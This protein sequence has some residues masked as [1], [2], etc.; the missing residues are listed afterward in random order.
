MAISLAAGKIRIRYRDGKTIEGFVL[1]RHG[2]T[3]SVALRNADDAVLFTCVNGTWTSE[4]L[5][6][7]V[8][9]SDWH[10]QVPS[11]QTSEADCIC[12]KEL[13]DRLIASLFCSD[14]ADF[15]VDANYEQ[16][17]APLLQRVV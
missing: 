1:A 9:Q 15:D 2:N 14:E 11:Q 7:I 16:P 12:S 17:Y 8:I 10:Q 3:M 6:P 4:D 5:E 13:A